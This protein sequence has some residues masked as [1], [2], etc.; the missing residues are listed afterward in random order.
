MKKKNFSILLIRNFCMLSGI[1]L[2]ILATSC[3]NTTKIVKFDLSNIKSAPYVSSPYVF[4]TNNPSDSNH[5]K[6]TDI[7]N[8]LGNQTLK[9]NLFSLIKQENAAISENEYYLKIDSVFLADET[10]HKYRV[11]ISYQATPGAKHLLGNSK[12]FTVYAKAIANKYVVTTNSFNDY[13][14]PVFTFNVANKASLTSEDLS[15]FSN[16]YKDEI[17][18]YL[19]TLLANKVNQYHSWT[20]S[21]EAITSEDVINDV[22]INNITFLN[23]D[24]DF[25]VAK[26]IMVSIHINSASSYYL[27]GNNINFT[28]VMLQATSDPLDISSWQTI[29]TVNYHY[30]TDSTYVS[31]SAITTSTIFLNSCANVAYSLFKNNH[32][33]AINGIDYTII[34]PTS[35]DSISSGSFLTITISSI[36]GSYEIT[37]NYTFQIQVTF[38]KA[39]TNLNTCSCFTSGYN[40]SFSAE[41]QTNYNVLNLSAVTITEVEEAFEKVK[42]S[43]TGK[44]ATF[45]DRHFLSG[46]TLNDISID[47]KTSASTTYN[48]A[49]S[50][51][52]FKVS[53]DASSS[54]ELIIGSIPVE[55]LPSFNFTINKPDYSHYRTITLKFYANSSASS[56]NVLPFA[57]GGSDPSKPRWYAEDYDNLASF[58]GHDY[59][60][61]PGIWYHNIAK[62]WN[63]VAYWTIN[64]SRYSFANVPIYIYTYE[65]R[66]TYDATKVDSA[67]SKA[68][69]T[70]DGTTTYYDGMVNEGKGTFQN[71]LH[72]LSLVDATISFK[73][74]D[75]VSGSTN[76]E[77]KIDLDAVPLDPS[78]TSDDG[79]T[80]RQYSKRTEAVMNS[81]QPGYASSVPF[82]SQAAF[83]IPQ[84][85]GFHD[86]SPFY[87]LPWEDDW[88]KVTF[89]YS[90]RNCWGGNVNLM[91]LK[92]PK[93]DYIDTGSLGDIFVPFEVK[94]NGDMYDG[95]TEYFIGNPVGDLAMGD[96][97]FDIYQYLYYGNDTL[98]P[99]IATQYNFDNYFKDKYDDQYGKEKFKIDS[100]FR[101]WKVTFR[102]S[103]NYTYSSNTCECT[104]L[105]SV[106]RVGTM[107]MYTCGTNGGKYGTTDPHQEH[108][109]ADHAHDVQQCVSWSLNSRNVGKNFKFTVDAASGNIFSTGGGKSDVSGITWSFLTPNLSREVMNVDYR[110]YT[111]A[112]TNNTFTCAPS[113]H[114]Y[115]TS[116]VE[117]LGT[118]ASINDENLQYKFNTN[119]ETISYLDQN[120]NWVDSSSTINYKGNNVHYFANDASILNSPDIIYPSANKLKTLQLSSNGN[121][122]GSFLVN[123]LDLSQSLKLS[124]LSMNN[125]NGSTPFTKLTSLRLPSSLTS[126]NLTNTS[127]FTDLYYKGTRGG[128]TWNGFNPANLKPGQ[129]ITVHLP[130]NSVAYLTNVEDKYVNYVTDYSY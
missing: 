68:G 129:K 77:S 33:N 113:T 112:T 72:F 81:L 96:E 6:T 92:N 38:V 126:F 127:N 35:P 55:Q 17:R 23:E 62:A 5:I 36:S 69:I 128:L 98:I 30:T 67:A 122:D 14:L 84:K 74:S 79:M 42:N 60:P 125:S 44:I 76:L 71:F 65:M 104:F 28:G 82:F 52:T 75:Y 118:T 22:S 73:I 4:E 61:H 85:N 83:A 8:V 100:L 50:A 115:Y 26:N 101:D 40:P 109:F 9:T 10:E 31:L 54:S 64:S 12:D 111:S 120:N 88:A 70:A 130:P 106:S 2:P 66:I 90:W 25:S 124:N 57:W 46:I 78:S 123:N 53:V 37:G 89:D 87:S 107:W 29:N 108:E 110:T 99:S 48:F 63:S 32:S 114:P 119:D 43:L 116:I 49:N 15:N 7:Y 58:F 94:G 59:N 51:V 47:I 19:S 97:M 86:D 56:T 41:E 21:S 27:A 93:N 121:Y 3:S 1:V 34:P 80:N 18:S 39:L 16:Y 13:S 45:L 91:Y 117:G 102:K 11:N 105:D 103:N 20:G 95:K 24:R